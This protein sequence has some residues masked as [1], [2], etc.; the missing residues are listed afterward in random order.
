LNPDLRFE[1]RRA[2]DSSLI[3][4]DTTGLIPR[5]AQT[6]WLPYGI[7]FALPP[8]ETSVILQIY[9]NQGGGSGNDLVLDDITFTLCG[10]AVSL[11]SEGTYQGGNDVCTGKAV[12]LAAQVGDDYYSDPAYQWQFS[13]D[14]LR[15]EDV[16]GATATTLEVPAAGEADSGW[17]RILVA[18][19][20]NIAL[21]H[22]RISSGARKLA[23]W[24][25]RPFTISTNS[26]VCQGSELRLSAAGGI[27]YR[28]EGPAGFTSPLDSLVFRP[29]QPA[30]GG[31][32]RLV[33]TTQGGCV[34]SAE[35]AVS[36][37]ADDLTVSL[38]ADTLFCQ[39]AAIWLQVTNP[40]A[41][42]QWSTGEKTP[43]VAIDTPGVYTVTVTEGACRES[44]TTHIREAL[45]PAVNLGADTVLC[46]GEGYTL[47]A[48]GQGAGQ[49]RWND[50]SSLP[51]HA[52]SEAGTYWVTLTGVCGTASDTIHVAMEDCAR[53]LLF[54][55]AFTPNGDGTNDVFGPRIFLRIGHYNLCVFDRWGRRIFQ[56]RDP[57]QGWDGRERGG[58]A[59]P[60]GAYLWIATYTVLSDHQ[61]VVQRGTVTLLR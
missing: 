56:S 33:R 24:R 4:E 21:D 51:V 34:T 10:P 54:P 19:S 38:P 26:P 27:A 48:A 16:S 28:W 57:G 17:Y 61:P 46:F 2:S 44:D 39:G 40:G 52:V 12:T 3:A 58:A 20:G 43:V 22:C 60:L 6:Q 47:N 31:S 7:P 18:E 50:G 35:T 23:V 49:Y 25:P 29:A 5:S 32:Y 41:V 13:A 14:T 15:W 36:V 53:K 45:R 8:G 42:Y 55:T 59:A 11:A 30:E 9:N 1:I 37:Q